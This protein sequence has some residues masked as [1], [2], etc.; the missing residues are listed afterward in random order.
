[1]RQYIHQ[2]PLEAPE[3]PN[4]SSSG[5]LDGGDRLDREV[6]RG[7]TIVN[8]PGY[9]SAGPAT[10]GEG[11]PN[12]RETADAAQISSTPRWCS[13]SP[14]FSASAGQVA[15]LEQVRERANSPPAC[16]GGCSCGSGCKLIV[17]PTRWVLQAGGHLVGRGR[18][19]VPM[20]LLDSA[21]AR[22]SGRSGSSGAPSRS[23]TA[24]AETGHRSARNLPRKVTLCCSWPRSSIAGGR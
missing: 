10:S 22:E 7:T 17:S 24:S 14:L 2:H 15:R 1:M 9:P 13:H 6:H 12:R 16:P 23:P 19:V 8:Q 20:D 4:R 18:P 21:A 5:P 11:M 3:R